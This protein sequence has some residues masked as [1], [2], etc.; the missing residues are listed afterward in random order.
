MVKKIIFCFGVVVSSY[1][2]AQVLDEYPKNQDFYEGGNVQFYKEINKILVENKSEECN[3]NEIYQPRIIVKK[4]A[5]IQIIKDYD[6]ENIAKN[7]CAYDKAMFVLKNLSNWKPAVVH[8]NKFG[9]ITEFIIYPKDV[10]S[11][12]REGYDANRY[13]IG[14]Q[15]PKGYKALDKDFHDNFM[16][17]FT[18]YHING[19]FNLEFYISEEGKI[20][21]PRIFPTI[22]DPVFNKEFLRTLSRLKKVWKPALYNNIPIKYRIS[23]PMSF[24]IT[25]EER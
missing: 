4:D 22:F 20:I 17:L 6:E 1:F 13:V 23:Y 24:S 15:Y 2:N 10:M 3:I 11:N 18:D 14:A 16:A 5:T 9:A 8:D 19:K 25:F 12:Y 7:K 21:D